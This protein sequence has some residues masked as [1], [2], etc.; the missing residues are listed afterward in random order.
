[1]ASRAEMERNIDEALRPFKDLFHF[2]SLENQHSAFLWQIASWHGFAEIL[3][4]II[5][6]G[7]I[8]WKVLQTL[9]FLIAPYGSAI[10]PSS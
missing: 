4:D 10:G 1:M 5:S 9:A 7:S 3:N 8:T 2:H 6:K